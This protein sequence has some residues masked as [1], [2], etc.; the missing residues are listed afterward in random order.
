MVNLLS[1]VGAWTKGNWAQIDAATA[2]RVIGLIICATGGVG[3]RRY[4]FDIGI[5]APGAEVVLVPDIDFDC[6]NIDQQTSGPYRVEIDIDPGVRIAARTAD[7]AGGNN[8]DV[9]VTEEQLI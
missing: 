8:F 5:G 1:G 3:G 6:D 7:M 4:R 2:R 9:S